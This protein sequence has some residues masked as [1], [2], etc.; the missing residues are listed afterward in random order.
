MKDYIVTLNSGEYRCAFKYNNQGSMIGMSLDAKMP[1]A[2]LE[3]IY[4]KLP[5]AEANLKQ[6]AQAFK[7]T[8]VSECIADTSFK[9]FWDKFGNKVGNKIR[10]DKLYKLLSDEEKLQVMSSIKKYHNWLVQ[11]PNVQQLYPETYLAQ[12]RWENQY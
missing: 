10:A 4:P 12:R 9:A 6:F 1:A 3:L 7:N 5:L 11:N 8:T 2:A